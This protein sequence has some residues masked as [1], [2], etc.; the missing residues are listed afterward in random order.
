M[1]GELNTG[2]VIIEKPIHEELGI[3][4]I[5]YN[6]II[7]QRIRKDRTMKQV[8]EDLNIKARTVRDFEVLYWQRFED[9]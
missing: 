1:S 7:M 3:D 5:L 4:F 8:C 2:I 6:Q 9:E